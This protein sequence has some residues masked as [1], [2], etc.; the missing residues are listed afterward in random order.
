VRKYQVIAI[1]LL[2]LTGLAAPVV[3][4]DDDDNWY[5]RLNFGGDFRLRYEGFDW[6]GHFDDGSR[7]RFRYRFRVGLTADITDKVTAGFQLRSG[8][9]QN[10]ISDNQSFDTGFDKNSIS[11]AQA[12]VEWR[13]TD[14]FALVVG[15]F[16]PKGRW[17][18]ADLQWDDD[19][20]TEGAMQMF[21]WKTGGV[22][23]KI[24]LNLWQYILNESSGS[25][26]AYMVGGQIVPV[27]ALGEKNDLAVGLSYD[28]VSKPD[29]VVGL[30]NDGSLDLDATHITNFVDPTTG[31]LVSDF[32]IANVFAEWKNKSS[33]RWPIK[34]TL[35][36]Y[37]N[38][39]ANDVAGEIRQTGSTNVLTTGVSSDNDTA[40]FARVQ[41]GDYKKP[42]QMA[43]RL[44][45]Y[46]SEPDAMLFAYSQSDTR[47]A[48]NVDGYRFDFRV[49]LPKQSHINLTW[50]QTDWKIG[51]DSTMNRWQ[52]DYIIKF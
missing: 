10:P 37:K 51:E 41:V 15:K 24:D 49:G 45:R 30:Y 35:Y 27:F 52:V 23:K 6:D 20:T 50:Y 9:S 38:L 40:I 13:A 8:N 36:M 39:G 33:E 44:S 42:G 21:D 26:D 48:S 5:D 43:F 29:V 7:H 47:R 19:V 46:D 18:A 3:A 4:S 12:Y 16:A 28:K 25:S 17:S 31:E 1:A 11:I 14:S 2:L 34:V 32:E 22:V